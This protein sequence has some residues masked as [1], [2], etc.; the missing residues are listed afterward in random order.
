M[1]IVIMNLT[2]LISVHYVVFNVWGYSMSLVEFLGTLLGILSFG[3]ATR[4]NLLAW[5]VGIMSQ[6]VFL[7]FFY[8]LQHL[9]CM[10]QQLV[11]TVLFLYGWIYWK[12]RPPSQ[13]MIIRTLKEGQRRVW[14]L[15]LGLS[16]LVGG[17]LTANMGNFLPGLFSGVQANS[18]IE[19]FTAVGSIAACFLMARKTVEAW[20]LWILVNMINALFYAFKGMY[21]ITAEYSIFLV[22]GKYGLKEWIK[23]FNQYKLTFYR[24]KEW[25]IIDDYA[26]NSFMK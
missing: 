1:E 19:V 8:Q 24:P 18:Y 4:L 13:A 26:R 23:E 9:S 3:L 5:P 11:L 15:G 10:L 21:F 22:I 7:L 25:W 2:N 16:V 20:V 17:T 12:M 14:I 6:L